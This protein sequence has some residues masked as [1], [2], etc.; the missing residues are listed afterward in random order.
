MDVIEIKVSARSNQLEKENKLLRAANEEKEKEI[1]TLANDVKALTQ[2]NKE[3]SRKMFQY[4][5]ALALA[6]IEVKE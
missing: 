5:T 4:R 6:G 2:L 1:K 3:L